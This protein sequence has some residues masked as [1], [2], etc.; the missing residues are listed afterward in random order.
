MRSD[1]CVESRTDEVNEVQ[2]T[3]LK[4][5]RWL[6]IFKKLEALSGEVDAAEQADELEQSEAAGA[7]RVAAQIAVIYLEREIGSN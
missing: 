1:S 5:F 2:I 3:G 4:Q 7:P 6:Q